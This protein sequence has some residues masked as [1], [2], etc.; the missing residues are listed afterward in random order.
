[1][2]F[3]N[4]DVDDYSDD[5][6]Y[7][8]APDNSTGGSYVTVGAV[9]PVAGPAGVGGAV[10]VTSQGDVLVS[11]VAGT[12][13]PI[14]TMG[15]TPPGT[16]PASYLT[17]PAVSANLPNGFGAT[18]GIPTNSSTVEPT[19]GTP[20]VSISYTVQPT[21]VYNSFVNSVVNSVNNIVNQA[22]NYANNAMGVPAH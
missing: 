2:G 9:A 19:V 4:D 1:M 11:A 21:Q 13:G 15:T 7:I 3:Y 16:S 5:K 22:V 14:A 20:G 6:S 17:G 10:T 18:V 12:A 8:T